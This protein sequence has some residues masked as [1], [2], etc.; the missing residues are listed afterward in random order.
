MSSPRTH[1]VDLSGMAREELIE[2]AKKQSRQIREKNTRI[3]A[4]ESFIESVTGVS[5]EASLSHSP[6]AFSN[7]PP[8][9]AGMAKVAHCSAGAGSTTATGASSSELLQLQQTLEGERAQHSSRVAQL[10]EQLRE[11]QLAYDQL[12]SKV[13]GW[14]KKVMTAMT[15]DQERIRGLEAQLAAAASTSQES[16]PAFAP[17]SVPVGVA[18][19]PSPGP[20][21]LHASTEHRPR[22]AEVS[23]LQRELSNVR[24]QLHEAHA[25]LEALRHS[26]QQTQPP[27]AMAAVTSEVTWGEGTF[28]ALSDNALP[29]S[30]PQASVPDI[31]PDVLHEAVPAK[32]ASW[33]GRVREAMLADKARIE[34]LE[35]QL[36]ALETAKSAGHA[37]EGDDA[38]VTEALRSEV[39]H[40]QG[41]LQA[42]E[43][44]REHVAAEMKAFRE[45]MDG[46][47]VKARTA[48]E[49]G[50]S[51][52]RV[53]EAEIQ[54]LKVQQLVASAG[55][56]MERREEGVQAD[57]IA[58]AVEADATRSAAGAAEDIP[59]QAFS[60]VAAS[61]KVCTDVPLMPSPVVLPELH[62]QS[63]Q[64][65][66][67]EVNRV[68]AENRRLH[69]VIAQ[70]SRFRAEVMR[71]VRAVASSFPCHCLVK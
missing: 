53:L 61:E 49:E 47:K 17:S 37:S 69:R 50:E 65:L 57:V 56:S 29:A 52:R 38:A 70:L 14:K 24:E 7:A 41:A 35:A 13:D 66:L 62:L 3:S 4:M 27:P 63:T 21:E 71:E 58:G 42:S 6:H 28:S 30:E 44:E 18:E 45:K 11:R 31:P 60:G 9:N 15:A 40:L 39:S 32:L 43:R 33:K 5:A 12:Q 23:D 2:I 10:E 26:S 54:C 55:A 51:Q 48:L 25:Q 64:A 46:W 8:Y 68:E 19:A 36:A 34:E 16:S 1:V 22:E 67:M 59:T 20:E